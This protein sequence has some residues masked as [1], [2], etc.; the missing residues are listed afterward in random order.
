M[1]TV[2]EMPQFIRSKKVY[3]ISEQE[4]ETIVTRFARN[5]VDGQVIPGTG[6]ARKKRF[7]GRGKGKIG[8]YRVVSFYSGVGILVFLLDVFAKG[9]GIDLTQSERNEL[10]KVLKAL[11]ETYKGRPR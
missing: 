4:M 2:V 6:G 10:K 3:G 1:H 9:D 8:G 7:G 5:P 11:V